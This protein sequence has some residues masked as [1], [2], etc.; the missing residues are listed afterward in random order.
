VRADVLANPHDRNGPVD[1]RHDFGAFC[2]HARSLRIDGRESAPLSGLTFTVKD[3]IDVAGVP[4][5]GGNPDW[6]KEQSPAVRHAV[7]VARLIDAGAT[8]FGKTITDELA[9]SL[10]GCNVH[11]GTPINPNAPD[12][13]PGGSSSGS[14]AAVAGRLVDFALGTDTGGSIRIPAAYCG[15][16]GLRPSHGRIPLDGVVR[17]APSFDTVGWLARDARMLQRVGAEIL[18]PSTDRFKIDRVVR[19]EDGFALADSRTRELCESLLDR[20]AARV[21]PLA[22]ARVCATSLDEWRTIFRTLRSIEVWQNKG[23]W[24]QRA[25]PKFGPDIERNFVV[26]SRTTEAEADSARPLRDAISR[27]VR[28]LIGHTGVLALPTAPGPAPLRDAPDGELDAIRDRTQSLTCMA[29]LAGL[30]QISIPAG[31]VDGAPVALSLISAKDND[32]E[33]L[34]LAVELDPSS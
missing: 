29:G 25:K 2:P 15:L 6:L 7:A 3:L 10:T 4:T 31:F 9:F 8:L 13:I 30:P 12:R 27:H 26:A 11:Y 24:I 5:G 18:G 16:Y 28:G 23:P 17:F 21:G 20:I 19:A 1:A 32:D 22:S 34:A 14:A 33:L